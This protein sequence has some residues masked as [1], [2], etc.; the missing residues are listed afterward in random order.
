MIGLGL[1]EAVPEADILAFADPDDADRDGISGR[2]NFAMDVLR[3]EVLGRFGVKA[4]Q[5]SILQQAAA[6]YRGD[7]G[8]TSS[9]FP[10][11]PCTEHQAA[12]LERASRTDDGAP[13]LA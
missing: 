9:L 7:V 3:G 11:G 2:P 4:T 13:E 6:A 10:T 12:C 1:L 8:V 5:P